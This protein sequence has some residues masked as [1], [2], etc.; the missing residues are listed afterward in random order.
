MFPARTLPHKGF[1]ACSRPI[2]GEGLT[3]FSGSARSKF[4]PAA[5]TLKIVHMIS[6]SLRP[7]P[8]E[9]SLTS[10][11]VRA[12]VLPTVGNLFTAETP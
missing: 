12:I 3:L 6:G 5:G 11:F 10:A 9:I 8:Q 4:Y 2:C 7:C 1:V